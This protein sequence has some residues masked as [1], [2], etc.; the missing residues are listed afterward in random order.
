[1]VN[2]LLNRRVGLIGA[3]GFIGAA[4]LQVLVRSGVTPRALCGPGGGALPVSA[5]IDSLICDLTN[6]EGLK[7]WISGLDV[8][9]HAAGPPSVQRSFEIPQQYARVHVEGTAALL[10]ACHEAKVDRLIYLS[11]AEV[12]GSPEVN[13]VSE[14]HRLQARS[15]YAAAKIGAEKMIE[16]Y[17]ESFGLK[18]VI[19]RPFSIY[20]PSPTPESLLGTI[21]TMAHSGRVRLRDLRPVRD[22]CYV[23]DLAKAVLQASC[24]LAEKLEI[25]NVGTGKG[26]NVGDFAALA[27]R[28]LGT[29]LP[30]FEDRSGARPSQSEIFELVADVSKAR[31]VLEW[32][33]ETSLEEGL[34]LSLALST[35]NA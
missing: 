9:I 7:S 33:P 6:A 30:V 29:N 20:G 24:L 22:Y 35:S 14:N 23:G 15:P 10:R 21:I 18:A 3:N 8:I 27:L 2:D 12:Y 17:A 25:F 26:T 11:S 34:R 16:A 4:I 13:P 19:L 28:S 31:N 32:H 1:M 5:G